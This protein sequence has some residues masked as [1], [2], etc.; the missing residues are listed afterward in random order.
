MLDRKELNKV[1]T[2][3]A[4]NQEFYP[5]LFNQIRLK[6]S[7]WINNEPHFTRRAIGEFLEYSK[8]QERIDEI[9]SKNPHIDQFSS[10]L[11]LRCELDSG[12]GP[13]RTYIRETEVRVYNPIG[14]QLIIFE[15][16]QPKAKAYKV[17]VAH[18]V[19]AFM[20]GELK[21]VKKETDISA[22]NFYFQCKEIL[23]L[24]PYYERPAAV[25]RLSEKSGKSADTV[26]AW[27]KR[28]E[29]GEDPVATRGNRFTGCLYINKD[30][31]AEIRALINKNPGIT[32]KDIIRQVP[33][34]DYSS[35]HALYSLKKR[36]I[37]ERSE[38]M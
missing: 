36:I 2:Q 38:A 26:Y 1:N 13:N 37:K 18:L 29:R 31:E 28:I 3:I 14:L 20:R 5:F 19:Y 21:P 4:V 22:Q 17:A 12:K 9:L 6:E 16:H 34:V 15:S 33:R 8:P 24:A 35:C 7:C 32:V 23:K 27:M 11:R 10:H 30:T 25:K